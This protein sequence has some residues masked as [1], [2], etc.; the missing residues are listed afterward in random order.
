M[1]NEINVYRTQAA[2]ETAKGTPAVA[3]TRAFRTV[4]GDIAV[5][6][7]TGSENVSDGGTL[8]PDIVDWVNS[9][10]GGPS[11]IGM[12][13]TCD[14]AAWLM[15]SFNGAETVTAN[16]EKATLNDHVTQPG[17]TSPDYITVWGKEGQTVLMR[18]KHN[19]CLITQITFEG[20]TANKALRVTPTVISLDPA[21]YLTA[22]PTW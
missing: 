6:R 10:A 7:D 16:A 9:V 14:E 21:Q 4:T 11:A 2:S 13:L 8:F 19:D 12:Q 17:A 3:P 1:S 5:N 22:D 15:R 18:L 20:S